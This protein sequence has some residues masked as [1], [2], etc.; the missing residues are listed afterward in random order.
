MAAVAESLALKFTGAGALSASQAKTRGADPLA[1]AD[2]VELVTEAG[3]GDGSAVREEID[4]A[5]PP[6]DAV[7]SLP[8]AGTLDTVW[9]AGENV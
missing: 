5:T 6:S 7:K 2:K 4:G 8:E 3:T 9:E 1:K